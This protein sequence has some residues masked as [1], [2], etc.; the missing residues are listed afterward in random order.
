V[1]KA[2]VTE[3]VAAM[4]CYH[5]SG[6]DRSCGRCLASARRK[7]TEHGEGLVEKAARTLM[8]LDGYID[9][10]TPLTYLSAIRLLDELVPAIRQP[11][12]K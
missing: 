3:R 1:P 8:R 10:P 11:A 5:V 12:T 6:G 2:T 7:V 4:M 9:P